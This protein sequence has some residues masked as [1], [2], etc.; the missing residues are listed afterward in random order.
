[1]LYCG[2][3]LMKTLGK[4]CKKVISFWE[5]CLRRITSQFALGQG[6]IPRKTLIELADNVF[7]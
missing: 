7:K 3:I 6:K 1:M 2:R 4:D 5:S